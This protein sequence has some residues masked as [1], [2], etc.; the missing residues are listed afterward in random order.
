MVQDF[1]EID[2]KQ[3]CIILIE[4][5]PRILSFMPDSLSVKAEAA[6]RRMG[7]EVLKGSPV[8][9]VSNGM[10]KVGDRLISA[11]TVLWAAGVS[12]SP[13]ARSLAVPLD[14]VGRVKVAPDLSA[15]GH[16]EVFVIGDLAAYLDQTGTALPGLASVALQQGRHVARTILRRCRGLP[17]EPF[18]YVDRGTMATIGRAA[19]VANF[20]IVKLSGFPA[21]VVWIFVHIFLLIGFR[22]RVVVLLNWAWAYLTLQRS[23]RLITREP[24]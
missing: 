6:L 10:V 14:P 7:V 1:R 3:A 12:P 13:L 20:G 19:A 5:G 4:A 2:P 17:S 22:N 8:T 23:A 21:W 18:H 9:A 24:D 15:P 16:P 11:A